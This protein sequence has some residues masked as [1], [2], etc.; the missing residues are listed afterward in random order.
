MWKQVG[1]GESLPVRD[2]WM[3]GECL[4]KKVGIR[5][6]YVVCSYGGSKYEGQV[7]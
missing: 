6:P 7:A 1:C 5:A 3:D 4:K 2:S